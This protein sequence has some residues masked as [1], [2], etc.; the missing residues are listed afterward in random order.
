MSAHSGPILRIDVAG[1]TRLAVL[2]VR[3]VTKTIKRCEERWL[4]IDKI[5]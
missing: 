5:E 3:A 4:V 2:R 1:Y